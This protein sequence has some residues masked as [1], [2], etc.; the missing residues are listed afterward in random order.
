MSKK[1]GMRRLPRTVVKMLEYLA[2]GPLRHAFWAGGTVGWARQRGLIVGKSQYQI[3]DA[4][5]EA[6]KRGYVV[7][8][9][10]P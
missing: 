6:L 2:P 3:T 7:E 5:R 1:P 8:A 10:Q 9:G 4:G